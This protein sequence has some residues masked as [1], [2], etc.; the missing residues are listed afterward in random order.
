ML[1]GLGVGGVGGLVSNLVFY[2]QSSI[3][4][5]SG[6]WEGG[7]G[8]RGVGGGWGGGGRREGG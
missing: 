4:V 2:A 7:G 6:Q 5:I 1:V 8:M 3:T